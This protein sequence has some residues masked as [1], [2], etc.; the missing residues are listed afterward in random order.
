MRA[1][2]GV[3]NFGFAVTIY[4]SDGAPLMTAFGEPVGPIQ[5]GQSRTYQLGVPDAGYAPGSYWLSLAIL[6][7]SRM[8]TD[9]IH[10]VLHFDVPP[11]GRIPA[12]FSQ[13]SDNWGKLRIPLTCTTTEVRATAPVTSALTADSGQPSSPP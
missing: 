2:E 11:G 13:W 6:R 1:H 5:A 12:G 10:E 9:A 7:N 8:V 4:T 3:A